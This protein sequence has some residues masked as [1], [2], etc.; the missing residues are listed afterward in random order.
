MTDLTRVDD[1]PVATVYSGHRAGV[2]VAVKV[3]PKRFD[4]R[5]MSAFNKEQAKLATV[6]RMTSI[7]MVDG[8]EEAAVRRVRAAHGTVHTV[9]GGPGGTRGPAGSGRRSGPGPGD[10]RRVGGGPQRWGGTRRRVPEQRAVPGDQRTGGSGLRHNAQAGLHQGPT[11]R[12]RVPTPE[13]LRTGALNELTDLYGLGAVLHFALTARSPHPGRL[14]EQPGERVLRILGEPVPAINRQ[15]VP[16]GLSTLVARLLATTPDRR[17]QDAE[18]GS[19]PTDEQCC[20]PHQNP[21]KQRTGTTSTSRSRS[22]GP[23]RTPRRRTPGLRRLRHPSS[24]SNLEPTPTTVPET[25]PTTPPGPGKD[26][27]P[28]PAGGPTPTPC[29]TTTLEHVMATPRPT[30]STP[31]TRT[32]DESSGN[33]STRTTAASTAASAPTATTTRSTDTPTTWPPGGRGGGPTEACGESPAADATRLAEWCGA[34]PAESCGGCAR[35]VACGEVA[36]VDAT[37][38]VGWRG[39]GPAESCGGCAR[40]VACGGVAAVDATC[41]VGWRGAGPAESRGGDA[42]ADASGGV[43]GRVFGSPAV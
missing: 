5:T 21:P 15:D 2:P 16:V 29:G 19:G 8:V 10:G 27:V 6:R 23:T 9:V 11:T 34:G 17:P 33:P 37:C 28:P 43:V 35:A 42:T 3:F 1:G 32:R 7:L 13:T 41:L 30:D 25:T 26:G 12:D 38:L 18:P 36:A 24:G 14:G 22:P 4:K 20:R 31:K 40:A 39:A